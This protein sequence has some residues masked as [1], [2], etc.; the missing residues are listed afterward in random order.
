MR[1]A[2]LVVVHETPPSPYTEIAV[3]DLPIRAN[4]VQVVDLSVILERT[5]ADR[6]PAVAL[7]F[8]GLDAKEWSELAGFNQSTLSR[9]LN[10]VNH[11]PYGAAVRLAHV[12]GL[13][14]ILLFTGWV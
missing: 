4:P 13:D 8:L 11:L 14:P 5:L 10:R 6:R 12:L 7:A 2:T 3:D 1:S 9:W